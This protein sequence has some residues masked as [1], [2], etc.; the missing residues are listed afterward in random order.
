MFLS[1]F[2]NIKAVLPSK[3]AVFQDSYLAVASSSLGLLIA[4]GEK[5]KRHE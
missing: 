2:L 3:S 1:T 4:G 5:L